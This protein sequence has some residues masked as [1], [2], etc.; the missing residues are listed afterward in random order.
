MRFRA[1]DT[2]TLFWLKVGAFLGLLVLLMV[3]PL[4]IGR[5][6]HPWVGFATAV[7]AVPIWRFLGPS[8]SRGCM[9]GNICLGGL[10][11]LVFAAGYAL[12]RAL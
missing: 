1:D 7:S 5:L 12:W 2:G 10:F 4:L 3:T 11:W 9:S 6:V 8:P